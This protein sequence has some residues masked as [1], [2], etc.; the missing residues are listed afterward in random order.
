MKLVT[1]IFLICVLFLF[2]C[3]KDIDMDQLDDIEFLSEHKIAL[4]HFDLEVPDFLDDLNNE[5]LRLSDFTRIPIFD[6]SYTEDYL[7]Q[8]DFQYVFSNSF[9]RGVTIQYQFFDIYG[10]FLH[11]LP[12]IYIPKG[13]LDL[14][15]TQS[16]S[17]DDISLV[18]ATDQVIV[19]VQL[20]S[21]TIPLDPI[22]PYMFSLKSGLF[23]HYK[24]TV[25]DE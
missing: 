10:N 11:E 8:A 19:A 7:I 17:G 22:Q 2:G 18:S 6:G 25:E 14:S 3:V 12:Q 13:A 24:I 5:K 4:I 1:P 23:L 16:I 21:G 9:D 20:D 15:V